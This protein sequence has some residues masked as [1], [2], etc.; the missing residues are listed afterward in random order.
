MAAAP[1][2][3]PPKPLLVKTTP[4][5]LELIA[6]RIKWGYNPNISL[7]DKHDKKD[8]QGVSDG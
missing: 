3:T 7:S 2:S 1:P 5:D 8:L 6:F 4:W